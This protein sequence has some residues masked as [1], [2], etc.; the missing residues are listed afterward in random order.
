ML[1]AIFWDVQNFKILTLIF[2]SQDLPTQVEMKKQ[3][4]VPVNK[5]GVDVIQQLLQL[6]EASGATSGQKDSQST[7][8]TPNTPQKVAV[9]LFCMNY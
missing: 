8:Q 3:K 5:I 9:N 4:E 7:E 1:K 2:L 6:S